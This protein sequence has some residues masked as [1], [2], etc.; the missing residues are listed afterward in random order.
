M[1]SEELLRR[2]RTWGGQPRGSIVEFLVY[3][4][5]ERKKKLKEGR[6]FYFNPP[7]FEIP[8][9]SSAW[10]VGREEP[11]APNEEAELLR[12]EIGYLQQ[13]M[14]FVFLK[15]KDILERTEYVLSQAWMGNEI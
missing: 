7:V 5:L 10:F 1:A 14:N 12:I 15:S 8:L 2:Y 4:F 3:E 6:D 9:I 13:D 11:Y